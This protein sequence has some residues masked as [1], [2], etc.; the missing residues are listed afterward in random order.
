MIERPVPIALIEDH[1]PT[2]REMT[3][4]LE[5]NGAFRVTGSFASV[6]E[7]E[8][9]PTEARLVLLDLDLPGKHGSEA[10]PEIREALP[11][12][13][14]VVHTV[15]ED[16]DSILRCIKAGVDGYL[17]KGMHPELFRAELNVVLL[18]GAPMT[19]R[20]ADHILSAYDQGSLSLTQPTAHPPNSPLTKREQEVLNLMALG[21][22]YKEA[23][24][25]LSV[26]SG[27]IRKHIEHIYRKLNVNSKVEAINAA[28]RR[29]AR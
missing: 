9:V 3:R 6:E 11:A 28:Y 8:L 24:F 5:E 27:T 1:P 19:A 10:I 21:L 18:G 29:P 14:I 2:R 23:A 4:L 26:S 20:V 7:A 25:R 15:F 13:K 22:T 16:V 12:A 17:L